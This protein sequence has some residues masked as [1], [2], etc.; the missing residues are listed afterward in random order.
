MIPCCI[1][2]RFTQLFFNGLDLNLCNFIITIEQDLF[3]F[4]KQSLLSEDLGMGFLAVF[5]EV[6]DETLD[7]L[8]QFV[9]G[10]LLLDVH[11]LGMG[12]MISL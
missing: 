4:L 3:Y 9:V 2:Q 5:V 7:S 1:L 6:R 10:L 8:V 11:V 12:N